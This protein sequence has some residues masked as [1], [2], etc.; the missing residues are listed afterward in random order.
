MKYEV[1]LDAHG[2]VSILRHTGTI[3]D[4][5]ELNLD[6]Y[7][8]SDGRLHA[9]KLGKNRLI[10][11]ESKWEEIQAEKQK[12]ADQKE[13]SRLKAFLNETDYITARCYE[14]IM[15]LDNPL[16][17]IADVIRIQLKYSKQY[18]SVIRERV[19]ARQRIEELE[20]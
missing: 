11:D 15:A 6:D 9:Y 17:Y 19:W 13:I 20:K 12:K 14:E 8:L 18:A 10:F 7:D 1:I 16:T 4:Y 5:V 2:Y 3:K